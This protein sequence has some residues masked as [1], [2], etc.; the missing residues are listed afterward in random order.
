M[1]ITEDGFVQFIDS[2]LLNQFDCA[3][4]KTLTGVSRCP[5]S[6]EL[7]ISYKHRDPN[8]IY[9]KE[10]FETWMIGITLLCMACLK[11]D[12]HLYDWDSS[13]LEG[14]ILEHLLEFVA[15]N[16]SKFLER[17]IKGCLS[18]EPETRIS[19]EGLFNIVDE[20]KKFLK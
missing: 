12:Y 7:L 2:T 17:T 10:K 14:R 13:E 5:L 16:Y 1:F 18:F 9:N 11:L 4:K 19:I 15:G 8:P 3:Y 6:P 20:R